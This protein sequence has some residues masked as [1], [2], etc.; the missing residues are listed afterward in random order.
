MSRSVLLNFPLDWLERMCLIPVLT[1][2]VSRYCAAV[3]PVPE[4]GYDPPDQKLGPRIRRAQD[5]GADYHDG[6]A[7]QNHLL[8]TNA[9]AVD[10]G[11]KAP[12][13]A[14]DI[15]DRSHCDF[16]VSWRS[17]TAYSGLEY[18]CLA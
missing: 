1:T 10:E 16:P 8:P 15:I 9:V 12:G 18:R 17:D 6:T 2:L 4:P 3:D 5:D 13:S 11:E 7:G 14:A